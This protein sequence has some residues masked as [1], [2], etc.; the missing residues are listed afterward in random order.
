MAGWGLNPDASSVA[1]DEA[2]NYRQAEAGPTMT[3]AARIGAEEGLEDSL[4]IRRR[5]SWAVV[6]HTYHDPVVE[7]SG[8]DEHRMSSGM[9]MGVLEQVGEGALKLYRVRLDLGDVI[10]DLDAEG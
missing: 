5:N 2:T 6:H 10:G 4:S 7:T 3:C 8:T 9:A 1:F